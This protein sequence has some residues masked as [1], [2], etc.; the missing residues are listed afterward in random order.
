MRSRL[1]W[2]AVASSRMRRCSAVRSSAT[3]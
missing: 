2:P 3:A 1:S